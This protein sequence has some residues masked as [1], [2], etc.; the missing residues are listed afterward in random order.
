MALDVSAVQAALADEQ[1]DGWLLYDFRGSNPIASR[2]T[3]LSGA[4]KMATRRWY[5]LIPRTGAPRKLVHAIERHN[6]DALP[7]ETTVYSERTA[8]DRQLSAL[9]SGVS[10]VAMEYSPDCA[11]PHISK[12]DAGTIELLRGRG[13]DV[14]SSGDLVQRF[15]ACW[16][17]A[18]VASHRD[19]SERLHRVKDAAFAEIARRLHAEQ[20]FTE[21]D[22]QQYMLERFAAEGIA[23]GDGPNVSAQEN[24]ADPHYL[25]AQG[26][27]RAIGRNELILLDLWAKR[28]APGA[29][30]ADITWM[31]FTGREI[32]ATIQR[33]WDAVAGARD[34]AVSFVQDGIRAGRDLRGWQVDQAAR[35]V[36]VDAGFGPQVWHRTGHSLGEEVHGNGVHMDDFETHDDRRLLPGLGFT[37]EPGLYFDTFGVRSELNMTVSDRDAIVT[38]PTQAQIVIVEDL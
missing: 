18:T 15:E 23:C 8:L 38:G 29:V 33:V 16:D 37:I 27:A 14:R 7:G 34:A 26:H 3:G 22:I 36:L 30:Y 4:G 13:V 9:L 5:Y 24:S 25:P 31:G 1:L 21:Y 35:Q 19:A 6:L 20:P 12:I 11:I 17:A 32:P 2:L 28:P 10:R